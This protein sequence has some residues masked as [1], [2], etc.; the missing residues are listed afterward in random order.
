[1]KYSRNFYE[2]KSNSEIFEKLV[3][4]KEKIGHY[5]VIFDDYSELHQYCENIIQNELILIGIGGSSL[6]SKAIYDFLLSTNSFEK[7]LHFLDTIDPL[8]LENTLSRIPLHDSHFIIIS[9]SGDTIEPISIAKYID[10]KC[11]LTKKNTTV[12]S[13]P[14]SSLTVFAKE[15]NI[16]CFQ[17]DK[18]V[19]GRFSVF[20]SAGLLPLAAVGI[21]TEELI[22][23]CVSAFDSFFTKKETYFEIFSKARFLVENKSRF[24]INVIFSYSAYLESF[25]KWFV[26]LWAESL[27][28]LNINNTHQGLTPVSLIGPIDQHSFLQLIIDGPRD[29][30][31]TFLKID[32][33]N[34]TISIP[35]ENIEKFKDF[36]LDY[37]NGISFN[38]LLNIQADATIESIMNKNDIP[39][40]VI[41][42]PK[43]NEFNIGRLMFGF[44]LLVS[45]IGAFLQIETYNQ[46]GVEHG[47]KILKDKLMTK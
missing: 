12:V 41:S 8:H 7:N 17:I 16:K 31:I 4:E 42:I 34:N 14:N 22:K 35:I 36:N 10:T 38:D 32:D 19:S 43:V 25:N 9:K 45:V 6:G 44:Q 46:P 37:I 13:L 15:N 2:I 18:N 5:N 26:Q 33:L 47:K 23:G 30:T 39:C 24:N 27:G 21:N 29:K 28:K 20:S 40:D 1:M 3:L 11:A